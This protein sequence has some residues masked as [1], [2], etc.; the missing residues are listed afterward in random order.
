M[1]TGHKGAVLDLAWCPHNDNVI[2]SASDDCTIKLWQIPDEG[3]TS[4]LDVPVADLSGHLKR[5]TLL[6]WHPTAMNVL[7][8][9]SKWS[10]ETVWL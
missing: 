5:V 7:A 10:E 4:N 2:A 8:S 1:V 6:V 3:L 9:A